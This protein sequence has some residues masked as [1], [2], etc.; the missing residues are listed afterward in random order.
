MSPAVFFLVP[1]GL[2]AAAWSLCFTAPSLIRKTSIMPSDS[3]KHQ[4]PLPASVDFKGA[5]VSIPWNTTT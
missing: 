1:I 2:R 4:H 5:F 3:G